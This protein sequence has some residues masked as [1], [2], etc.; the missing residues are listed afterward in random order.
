[1]DDDAVTAALL[2]SPPLP[3]DASSPLQGVDGGPVSS[4]APSSSSPRGA[5]DTPTSSLEFPLPATP[6]QPA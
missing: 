1:M 5:G 4:P 6:L 3:A 2:Q